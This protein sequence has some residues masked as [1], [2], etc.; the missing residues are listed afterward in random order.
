VI[1]VV[2][3]P[4]DLAQEGARLVA[5]ALTEL[6]ASQREMVSFLLS[7]GGTPLLTYELLAG[8]AGD[9][10]PWD[11]VGVFWG[12]ERCVP[13]SDARSNYHAVQTSGLLTRSFASV[14]RIPAELSPE[15]AA[16]TYEAELR[17]LFPESLYPRFDLV[18]LGLGPDGHFASIFPHSPELR[19]RG[20]WV[21]A[22]AEHDGLRRATVTMP[23]FASARR[24]LFFV[25][26][27]EKA[28]ALRLT[29]ADS[30]AH[31]ASRTPARM[32]LEMVAAQRLGGG[33]S[34][35]VTWLV[36]KPAASLFLPG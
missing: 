21:T 1:R 2:P 27:R 6:V 30:E 33:Q 11:R 12:D 24:L 9:G 16:Q 34:P 28:K 19:E 5:E 10:I 7:G 36:D 3:G 31:G 8:I 35:D 29:L 14:C 13:P 17:Q 32:L 26:G 25:C 22:T 15:L 4:V 23:V 20:R 18:L